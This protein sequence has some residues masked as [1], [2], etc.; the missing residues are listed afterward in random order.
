MSPEVAR[1]LL[2]Q[3]VQYL[4]DLEPHAGMSAAAYGRH[5]YAVERILERLVESACDATAHVL[6]EQGAAK[7]D[8]YRATF[9]EGAARGLMPLDLAEELARAAGM[10]NILIHRYTD[11]DDEIVRKSVP[12]ALRTFREFARCLARHAWLPEP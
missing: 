5:H 3:I 4:D 10:R 11:I 9:L 7:P 1:R 8:T 12:A 6:V 2:A